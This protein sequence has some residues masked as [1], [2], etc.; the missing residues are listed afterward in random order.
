[1]QRFYLPTL[2]RHPLSLGTT[3]RSLNVITAMVMYV[4]V[5]TCIR[6][7]K[8]SIQIT[9]K[10]IAHAMCALAIVLTESA[11]SDPLLQSFHTQYHAPYGLQ[12][13][14][15]TRIYMYTVH[16]HCVHVAHTH[17]HVCVHVHVHVHVTLFIREDN[18]AFA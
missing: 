18:F 3:P 10:C 8:L 13:Y 2:L 4:Y 9:T 12:Q 7:L 15:Y 1:M 14:N 5:Y 11:S 6:L 16:V 17:V